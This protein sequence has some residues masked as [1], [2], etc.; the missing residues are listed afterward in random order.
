MGY[1]IGVFSMLLNLDAHQL[2]KINQIATSKIQSHKHRG[3]DIQV[4]KAEVMKMIFKGLKSGCAYC[5]VDMRICSNLDGLQPPDNMLTLDV[6]NPSYRVL[7]EDN[8]KMICCR[9]N[10]IK[11]N[12]DLD[13]FV[14]HCRMIADKADN[15]M[16]SK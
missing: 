3:F 12:K 7:S 11:G 4:D 8:I 13:D 9:C 6:V 10:Q 5:G 15:L 1:G 16:A 2:L 14:F